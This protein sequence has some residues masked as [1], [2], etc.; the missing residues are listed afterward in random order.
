MDS[1]TVFQLGIISDEVSDDL[2]CACGLIR[3]WGLNHVELRGMW[4]KN[5]LALT[6]EEIEHAAGIVKRHRLTVTAVASPIF[7]SARDGKLKEDVGGDFQL[8]GFEPLE[9]QLNLIRKAAV[10]AKQFGTN[11]VRVF[12]FWRESWD[13]DLVDD[14]SNKLLEAASLARDLD[15]ILVVENEPVCVVGSGKELGELF[16]VIDRK[17]DADVRKHI[18]MLWDPGNAAHGGHETPYPNGYD[19]LDPTRIVHMHL[20]DSTFDEAGNPQYVPMGHGTIDYVR[21]LRQLKEDGYCG[22][23]V[24]EPHYHPANQTREWAA[25]VC[26]VAAKE[27]IQQAISAD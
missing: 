11:L 26:I 12:T 24:L 13:R 17:A 27:V 16:Q 22:S 20:K 4:G 2:D 7:K 9:E 14:V 23:L 5:I 19:S 10:I 6:P 18:A 25:H 21:H 8:G 1:E 3:E 15:V